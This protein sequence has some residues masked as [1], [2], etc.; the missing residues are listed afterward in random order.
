MLT[1]PDPT[2]SSRSPNVSAVICV[3]GEA[4]DRF[5][6]VLRH[7]SVGLVDQA[8]PLR[9]VSS[10]PRIRALCLGP[11]QAVIHPPFRWPRSG[12]RIEHLLDALSPQPP[13]VVH[14]MS[15]ASYR[16]AASIAGE[17]DAELVLQ[18]TSLVDCDQ[19]ARLP[20][21]GPVHYDAY[22]QP[23]AALLENQIR[24]PAELIEVIRP[25][26]PVAARKACFA[27]PQR[28]ATLLCTSRFVRPSGLDR[29][30]GAMEVLMGRGH[31]LQLFLIADGPL[32]PA[33]RRLVRL[34]GLSGCI[35]FAQG[36]P[37]LTAALSGA[38]LFVRPSQDTEFSAD[39]LQAMAAGLAVIALPNAACD[40]F[41]P[42]ET[43][44]VFSQATAEALADV[45]EA[46]LRDRGE[47]ERIAA[48]GM[49]HVRRHHGVSAMAE[50]T[51]AAYRKL[52]LARTTFA[53]RG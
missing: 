31:E 1:V 32:E 27:N 20:G 9:F 7:L 41:V 45:I 47:A 37:D 28:V 24:V 14:A 11:V 15:C 12:R 38:D 43:A 39:T 40:H 34:R 33:L 16:A 53:M 5:G 21:H 3:D 18:V 10:D 6:V 44:M 29:L 23:L 13:T 42:G 51:A 8:I 36:L 19:L 48:G 26:V 50:R 52:A 4:L 30:I 17:F 22:S 49:E 25:G 2:E 46:L 35:T